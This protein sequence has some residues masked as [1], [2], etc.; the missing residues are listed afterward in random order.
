MV[1]HSHSVAQRMST[2]RSGNCPLP[3]SVASITIIAFILYFISIYYVFSPSLNIY[4]IPFSLSLLPL[5]TSL[6]LPLSLSLF[7]HSNLIDLL[8][9]RNVRAKEESVL[10]ADI[11]GKPTVDIFST[12]YLLFHFIITSSLP[13]SLLYQSYIKNTLEAY[14]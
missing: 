1:A 8:S 14:R 10:R 6:S 7:V 13:S 4:I 3:S 2:V 11:M 12:L 9:E 5:S